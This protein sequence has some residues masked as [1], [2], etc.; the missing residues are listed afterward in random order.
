MDWCQANGLAVDP[1]GAYLAVGFLGAGGGVGGNTK[2]LSTADGSVIT[3]LDLGVRLSGYTE[4]GDYD[5]DWDA[6]G[7]VYLVDEY[8][9][10]W[11]AY[12]PPGAN[13]A[14]TLAL[15]VRS[16]H[17]AHAAALYHEHRSLCRND[18]NPLHGSNERSGL[19]ILAAQRDGR[20]GTLFTRGWRD[21]HGQRRCLLG[22][23]PG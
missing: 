23:G 22:G 21:Y 20:P 1:T 11:R 8:Y 4:K 10:V 18:Y 14:T 19:N 9:G 13:Q 5:V 2:I 15:P 12:S 16:S 7:N 17:R 3:N 6:V